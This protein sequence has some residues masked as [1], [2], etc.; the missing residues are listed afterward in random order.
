MF[1]ASYGDS[2]LV[3]CFGDKT[4]N[5]L[6]DMGFK[7]TYQNHI[8][9]NL[10]R[11]S[12][13]GE[14]LDLLVFTHIDKDH[15]QGGL[16]FIEENGHLD[17]PNI[18]RISE[19]WHNS[20]K[21]LQFDKMK[22]EIVTDGI[23]KNM[24]GKLTQIIKRGYGRE[25]GMQESSEIGYKQGSTLASLLYKNE[26]EEIWNKSFNY[27]AVMINSEK[28]IEQINI[29]KE[30]KITLLSPNLDKL[31]RLECEWKNKLI[32]LGFKDK[33]YSSSIMDDAFE[34]FNAN[35]KENEKKVRKIGQISGR[36]INIEELAAQ[37]FEP[38]TAAINGSSISFILEFQGKRV[39]FLGDSHSDIIE[40]SIRNILEKVNRERLYFDAVK[41]SHHGSKHNTSPDLLN[42][43]E[44]KRYIISTNGRGT[45][46]SHPDLETISRI[47]VSKTEFKKE[48]IFNF[49]PIHLFDFLSKQTNKEKY[50]YELYYENEYSQPAVGKIASI[51]I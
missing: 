43:V 36:E 28:G 5:I 40:K 10:K 26:Y 13:E 46:F 38:D 12:E 49:K 25:K 34:V 22:K 33:L 31:Q 24:Q 4:T 35:L 42:L 2:F 8:K 18:I 20:Y 6:I 30:V 45:G 3:R 47:I 21:H 9:N 48:L 44:A 27:D 11:I 50:N 19:I 14:K 51:I 16:Q 32:E 29:N 23:D 39:L 1:P 37:K 15:I 17:S 41:I 7:S